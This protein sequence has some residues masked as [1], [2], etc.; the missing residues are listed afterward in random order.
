[1]HYSGT[2]APPVAPLQ[3]RPAAP[4]SSSSQTGG[5]VGHGNGYG[6]VPPSVGI[7][8]SNVYAAPPNESPASPTP[9]GTAPTHR[10]RP[11]QRNK[12]PTPLQRVQPGRGGAQPPGATLSSAPP[13]NPR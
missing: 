11:L 3:T 12:V 9:T 13:S 4:P 8:P 5:G 1:M 2:A 6:P 10:V 7:A